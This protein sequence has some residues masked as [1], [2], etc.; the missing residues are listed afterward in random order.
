[1]TPLLNFR[2]LTL[3]VT[4]GATVGV[5][6]KMWLVPT[7]IERPPV[8][9]ILPLDAQF[10]GWAAAGGKDADPTMPETKF[11]RRSTGGAAID[12]EVQFIP[13]L[14]KHYVRNPKLALR[15]LPHGHLPLDAGLHHYV[16]SRSTVITNLDSN[17]PIQELVKSR[18]TSP[19][20]AH[21]VWS[22]GERNHLSTIITADG[23]A[24]MSTRRVARSMYLDHLTAGRLWGWLLGRTALP[25]RR[26]VLVH[27]S[28]PAPGIARE[29]SHRLL[30]DAW[31]ELQPVFHPVFPE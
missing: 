27:F 29:E 5:L 2:N 21:G 17:I 22:A 16:N 14:P 13:N 23:D 26:C 12:L 10:P 1:M 4:F 31:A 18:E 6:G 28:M 8:P 15:F 25:D 11:Y 30:E 7:P 19:R 9:V 20:S 3:M 24:S